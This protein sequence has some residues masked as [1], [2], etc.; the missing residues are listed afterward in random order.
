MRGKSGGSLG[1]N[2]WLGSR[3]GRF[4]KF[5]SMLKSRC[6]AQPFTA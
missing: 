1:L 5:L 3:K 4:G 6:P 2:F